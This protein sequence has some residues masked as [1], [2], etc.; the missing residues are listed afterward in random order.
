MW[1]LTGFLELLR[2]NAIWTYAGTQRNAAPQ[3][4]RQDER[5]P[6]LWEP[7]NREAVNRTS[8]GGGFLSALI[9]ALSNPAPDAAITDENAPQDANIAGLDQKDSK[10]VSLEKIHDKLDRLSRRYGKLMQARDEMLEV[11]N[12]EQVEWA[13][14]ADMRRFYLESQQRFMEQ[15]E[16]LLSA[17]NPAEELERLRQFHR[18]TQADL[19]A[20]NVQADITRNLEDRLSNVYFHL[21]R[22]DEAFMESCHDMASLWPMSAASRRQTSGSVA[23][24]ISSSLSQWSKASGGNTLHPTLE[25]Y[26]DKAGDVG[27]IGEELANLDIEY[28]EARGAR[29]FIA[30]RDDSL[31][32]SDSQFEDN[33]RHA[34]EQIEQRLGRAFQEANEL[35]QRCIDEG[36]DL[37]EREKAQ[38]EGTDVLLLDRSSEVLDSDDI[39]FNHAPPG[40]LTNWRMV[41]PDSLFRGGPVFRDPDEP[42]DNDYELFGPEHTRGSNPTQS[43]DVLRWASQL[44]DEE[45]SIDP[46]SDIPELR[47]EADQIAERDQA[48]LWEMPELMVHSPPSG[49]SQGQSWVQPLQDQVANMPDFRTQLPSSY[50]NILLQKQARN[51]SRNEPAG[52]TNPDAWTT[53]DVPRRRSTITHLQRR[54]SF[55]AN[56]GEEATRSRYRLATLRARVSTSELQLDVDP[57]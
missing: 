51:A 22:R 38:S 48:R 16:V 37:T 1:S 30:E 15:A 17:E 2:E 52:E 28:E 53:I 4:E 21:N 55:D 27:L 41:G 7:E 5:P 47:L 33:Y 25:G 20:M 36:L 24:A 8:G 57:G 46:E 26:Y 42:F 13:R 45:Q 11:Q 32:I 9:S 44:P 12:M 14:C 43:A 34:R 3:D 56:A 31:S 29:L 18:Q 6:S 54:Q 50:E 39:R 35:G 49:D 19:N 40:S 10:E 23:K